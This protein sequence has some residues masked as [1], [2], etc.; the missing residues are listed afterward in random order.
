[1][2]CCDPV[3]SVSSIFESLARANQ[4]VYGHNERNFSQAKLGNEIKA[5]FLLKEHGNLHFYCIV[6][7]CIL[8]FLI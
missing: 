3:L 5:R 1:M 8:S 6:I 7:V 2:Y 4:S